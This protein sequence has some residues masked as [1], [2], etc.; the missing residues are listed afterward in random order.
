MTVYF[1]LSPAVSPHLHQQL[2]NFSHCV[3][4]KM[5]SRTF[6]LCFP[7]RLMVL[8]NFMCL[9]TYIFLHEPPAQVFCPFCIGLSIYYWFVDVYCKY[10]PLVSSLFVF[11]IVTQSAK[12]LNSILSIFSFLFSAIYPLSRKSFPN[13]SLC[14]PLEVS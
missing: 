10:F 7:Q 9:L 1:I 3:G 11:A 13:P 6:N 2:F 8:S 5:A 14:F 12:I 4:Y